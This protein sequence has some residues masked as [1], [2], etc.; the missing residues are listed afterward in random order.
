VIGLTRG[1]R[2]AGFEVVRRVTGHAYPRNGNVASA[3]EK[4]LWELRHQGKLLDSSHGLRRMLTHWR[5][6]GDLNDSVED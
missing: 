2:E 1:E 5:E 4:V 6:S 3:T